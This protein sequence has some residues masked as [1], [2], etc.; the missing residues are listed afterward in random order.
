MTTS[1]T[2]ASFVGG[3]WVTGKGKPAQLVNPTTEEVLAETSTEGVDMR[4]AVTYARDVG[5][6]ALRALSFKER[7]EALRKVSRAIH[8]HR[9]ELIALGIANAGNTR[10]D[11]KFDIDGAS[12][13]L[14]AY[15]DLGTELGDAKLLV[16]GEPSNIGRSSKLTGQHVWTPREGVAVHINAFNFPAWG[17]AEKAAV[18]ILAGVPVIS[19][20]ATSTAL[21]AHRLVEIIVAEDL[22]PKGALGFLAGSTNDLV[23]HLDHQDVLAFTGSGAVGAQL[24]GSKGVVERSVRV[25]VEADSLNAA[26]LGPDA[27]PGSETFDL[28]VRDV[29]RDV[30]QKAGQKCTAIR[31]VFVPK[32]RL[33][34]VRDAIVER[35]ADV[36]VG[37]PSR[38][39]VGMGPL[40]TKKQLADVKKALDSFVQQGATMVFGA[41]GCDAPLGVAAGKGFFL[42]PVL[43]ECASVDAVPAIHE[44]EVFGPSTTLLPYDDAAQVVSTVRRGGGGL[45]A[46]LYT[47]DKSFTRTIVFGIASAHGRLVIGNEKIAAASIPP[48]TV[49]PNLVHGGPGRA[50]G[51]EELGGLRGMSLYLQRTALQG[52]GPLVA[53]LVAEGKRIA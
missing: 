15:A 33:E 13:T 10:G 16:D 7:G 28:F 47:D 11:A 29:V 48:G 41:K 25:N 18:A 53:A 51:G 12:A 40:A 43:L 22:L 23:D 8:A 27:E 24:R 39:D 14:A 44:H 19:K 6:K 37:D 32:D 34:A 46:S 49:L 45:V 42:S 31:R 3:A 52:Y 2:L 21:M 4:A 50:G 17:L 38:E 5:G 20:P 1:K 30:V 9:D 35:L 36:K 26:I